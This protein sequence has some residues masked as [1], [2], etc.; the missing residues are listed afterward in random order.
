MHY[1]STPSRE[2]VSRGSK[3]L[4]GCRAE[5][6]ISHSHTV[7]ARATM[8][9]LSVRPR[10]PSGAQLCKRIQSDIIPHHP[11]DD[12]A[13]H[14]I[15]GTVDYA[16]REATVG[17]LSQSSRS[18]YKHAQPTMQS[19]TT[20]TRNGCRE[21]RRPFAG[22]GQSPAYPPTTATMRPHQSRS[23]MPPSKALRAA[24]MYLLVSSGSTLRR[25]AVA[26]SSSGH[27]R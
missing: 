25:G 2:W 15:A 5:P 22:A 7:P 27:S 10:A 18:P 14:Y 24:R 16:R 12:A 23:N 9:G 8:R 3:T 26:P 19:D 17:E 4:R 13:S 6:C 1:H 21:G 20:P 11:Q